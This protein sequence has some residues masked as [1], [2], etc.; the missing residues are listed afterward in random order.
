MKSSTLYTLKKSCVKK[1]ATVFLLAILFDFSGLGVSA[2]ARQ[3]VGQINCIFQTRRLIVKRI[4][5]PGLSC[6]VYKH[7]PASFLPVSAFK[8]DWFHTKEATVR[9]KLHSK[10]A[11]ANSPVLILHQVKTIPQNG[12]NS[13]SLITG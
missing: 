7:K 3:D 11:L 12:K 2:P 9:F 4:K 13:P 6:R 1:L 5:F 8:L 10:T